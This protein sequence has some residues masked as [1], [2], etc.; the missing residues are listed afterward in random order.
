VLKPVLVCSCA[1]PL[2]QW[3]TKLLDVHLPC[4]VPVFVSQNSTVTHFC[5]KPCFFFF[6]F[7][8]VCVWGWFLIQFFNLKC[9]FIGILYMCSGDKAVFHSLQ[10]R[11]QCI[12]PLD[13]LKCVFSISALTEQ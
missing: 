13:K 4:I 8:S 9:L 7:S 5:L 12:I 1:M 3:E 10:H 11:M 2:A 6:L